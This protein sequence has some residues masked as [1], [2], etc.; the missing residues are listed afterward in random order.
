[1][2]RIPSSTYRLQLH[3]EFTFDDAAGIAE[4]LHLLGVSHVYSSPYL[5]ASPGSMHG[6]DVVSHLKV[7]EELGGRAGHERFCA[8]L[9]EANL[10]QVLDIVPNHMSLGKENRYWWDVLENGTSSRYASFF[11][12]DWQPQEERLRDK[13]LVP[14]LGDQ[15]GRVLKAGG[16]KVVRLGTKFQVECAGQ[17]LPVS[18]TSMP[19]ILARAAEYAKSD[20]LSFLAASFGRLPAPEYVDRRTIL[21][22]NRD[23]VVLFDLL[24]RLCGEEAGLCEAIDQAVGEL[25]GNL[26]GLDDFLNQQNYR[27]AYWK[28]ADQQM[29]YRRFFDVN[30][31]I[32][33]RVEREYVFEETHALVLNWL[34][35]GVLDGVRVDHPDGLRDPLEYMRRLRKHAP[36]AYVVGEKILE[37][38]EFLP[39]SWPIQGTSGYD[40]LNVAAGVLVAPDGMVELSSVYRDFT[41]QPTDFPAIAHEKKINVSQEALG[42]DVNRL[43]SLFV[44]ICEANRDQRDYTR[45]EVRRAVREV[46]ACFE[47]YRTYVVPEREE[48]TEE[49]RKHI[50]QATE[51]AKQQRQD[52]DGGL[53]DFMRDVLT[54]VV[55]GRQESEFVMRFQQFTGPVMA[56]GVED[57]AFYCFN[58]LT[59]MNE[60][61]SDPGRNGLS[62]AEFHAYC[63]KMQETH[64]LTMTTLSTH[65]TK[66]SDD[67]RA[68]LAVLSEIPGR[69]GAAVQRWARINSAFR[70]GKRGTAAMPDRNTEYLYYQTLIGA[71]PLSMERAQAYMLKAVREAKQQTSWVANNKEFEDSLKMFIELTM[72]YAPFLRELQQ[73]VGRVQH[74]GRV[75]SLAQ[76]LLKC[77]APGVPDL[78]QGGELWDLSLVDPDNRR[79]VDYAVRQRYLRELRQLNGEDVAAQVMLRMDEGLPKMWTIHKALELRRERPECFGAEAE[80]TPLEVDGAKHDHVI[81]YLRGEDVVTVVPRLSLLLDGVWKDTMVVLPKGRWRNRLTGASVS[82]GVIT[83]KLLLKDFPVALLV[84]EDVWESASNA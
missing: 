40:F 84:R 21:A 51:C 17:A 62:V 38:G 54:M 75:N 79:P 30:T 50:T 19:V 60:V 46:A 33:L 3:K 39:E 57:T 36:D 25:N 22:R 26:D 15:Y 64:P 45:A 68:R 31:L 35:H 49:D 12:I 24:E 16:I 42:S 65:D 80:Y 67:V 70:T 78:Y 58:R 20:T 66:R 5:Q 7:N 28:A 32:G 48:I 47:V 37:P 6:Y 52:I 77:T 4:Y 44:E 18:P 29:S 14:I 43:T 10:G 8:R 56:K 1:M 34:K 53:F 23:K 83:M 27:L 76:T 59:G 11:D 81:A 69:F 9:G 55:K 74:A 63:T 41:E 61:G 73:F 71:W 82:G 2:L 13:V 72:N